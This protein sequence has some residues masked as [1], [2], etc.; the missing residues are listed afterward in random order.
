MCV[1]RTVGT[2]I[3]SPWSLAVDIKS[4][5]M[6]QVCVHKGKGTWKD[7]T[8]DLPAPSSSKSE[9]AVET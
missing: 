9:V 2:G 1:Q 3:V 5:G 7:I 8:F 4:E 6:M